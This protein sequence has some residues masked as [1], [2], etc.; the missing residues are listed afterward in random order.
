MSLL[1]REDTPESGGE[2]SYELA[3]YALQHAFKD[4]KVL[5]SS[6]SRYTYEGTSGS[7][8]ISTY[9]LYKQYPNY[10]NFTVNGNDG[11]DEIRLWIWSRNGIDRANG[12]S[13]D[14]YM[15]G[16]A[17]DA[18]F[19]AMVFS[20][21]LGRDRIYFVGSTIIDITR[22]YPTI[23]EVTLVNNNDGTKFTAGISDDV[24][25]FYDQNASYYLTEDIANGRIRTVDWDE[26][27]FR[28]YGENADWYIKGL[29]T[30][31]QYHSDPTPA[32]V[33]APTPQPTP[34]PVPT[35]T[36]EP[37]P[38]PAPEPEPAPQPEPTPEPEPEPIDPPSTTRLLEG[39]NRRDKLTGTKFDDEIYGFGGNDKINGKKG[40]D[41]IDAG[42]GMK[43]KVKGGGGSD[44]FVLNSDAKVIIKDFDV[45][46]DFLSLDG[47][48]GETSQQQRG[49]N[50]LVLDNDSDVIAK[51]SG[52]FDSSQIN[53]I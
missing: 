51:L 50:F 8:D 27:S 39:T 3:E 37:Q 13:G 34:A 2:L 52:Q 20:G 22:P 7:D 26:L 5:G 48:T 17:A 14:D 32:P 45:F 40:D 10:T 19:A 25:Y 16:V 49:N 15:S 21:D 47:V 23:T 1:P 42:L 46:N 9:N 30:Y 6:S 12:G 4:D 31:S 44:I 53:F 28:A 24:E 43:N 29:D 33:P 11:D 38:E 36:P 18:G 41:L 35:P